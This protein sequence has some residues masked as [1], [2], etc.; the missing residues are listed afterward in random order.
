MGTI[1]TQRQIWTLEQMEIYVL[2]F[3][4][5]QARRATL[6]ELMLQQAVE[7][8]KAQAAT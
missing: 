1:L 8:L 6:A 4:E 2:A 5:D 3:V 7:M